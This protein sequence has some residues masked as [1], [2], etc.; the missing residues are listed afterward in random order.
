MMNTDTVPFF[1]KFIIY[2]FITQY[3][4]PKPEDNLSS[5]SFSYINGKFILKIIESQTKQ[6]ISQKQVITF[7]YS[8]DNNNSI[9][10]RQNYQSIQQS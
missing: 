3:T 2:H 4:L 7:Q 1:L 9:K 10:S 5:I 6:L 8:L